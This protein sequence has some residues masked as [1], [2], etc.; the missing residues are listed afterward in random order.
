MLAIISAKTLMDISNYQENIKNYVDIIFL[1]ILLVDRKMATS[2]SSGDRHRTRERKMIEMK[3]LS[4]RI[5]HKI[6][7]LLRIRRDSSCLG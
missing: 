4:F 1:K 7:P 5:K 2:Q 3:M 6:F